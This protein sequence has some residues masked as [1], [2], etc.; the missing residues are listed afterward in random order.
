MTE[1]LNTKKY[2]EIEDGIFEAILSKIDQNESLEKQKITIN[3]IDYYFYPIDYSGH[4]SNK[5]FETSDRKFC[6]CNEF[7][8]KIVNYDSDYNVTESYNAFIS[9]MYTRDG[10][11]Y[12]GYNYTYFKIDCYRA[13]FECEYAKKMIPFD[14]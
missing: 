2:V 6:L 14:V 5:Y 1:N 9:Q 3:N 10:T 12:S 4:N 7:I 8:Y 11:Y 13:K